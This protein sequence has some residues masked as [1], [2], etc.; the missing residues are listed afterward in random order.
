MF[1]FFPIYISDYC[2]VLTFGLISKVLRRYKSD[3]SKRDHSCVCEMLTTQMCA[4]LKYYLFID[5]LISFDTTF[6]NSSK[7]VQDNNY[8]IHKSCTR[9]VQ[10]EPRMI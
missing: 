7:T 2:I 10:P 4:T 3:P 8:I 9:G 1:V 6:F 5:R